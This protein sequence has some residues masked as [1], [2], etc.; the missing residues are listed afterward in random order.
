MIFYYDEQIRKYLLQF[1]R[2]FGSFTVQ[3]GFDAQS[4]PVY[5]QVPARYGDMSRQVGHILKDNSENTLNTIPFISCYVGSLEMKPDLRRYPQ[6]EE[7]LKVIEKKFDEDLHAYVE[8][9]GQ[10]YDVTRYTPVPYVLTMT[11]DIW[12]SNTDQKLQLLEQILVLF[13][14]GINLHTNENPLDWTS[15][16]YCEMIG[17]TWSSRTLPSGADNSIDVA[18]LTFQMPI[19][20]NPPARVSRMNIIQTILTQ[21]HTLDNADFET[22]S[23][24]DLVA[25]SEYIVTTLENYRVRYENGFATLLDKTG[26]VDPTLN[27]KTDVFSAYGELREGISQ[28]RLRQGNDVTDPSNDVIGTLNYDVSD[29]SRLIVNIDTDTLPIDTQGTVNNVINPQNNYPNDG[30]LPVVAAGQRYLVLDSTPD[31]SLW[32]NVTA[33]ANDIIKYNGSA[34]VVEFDASVNA[35]ANYVTNLHNGVQFEWT[36][37]FWQNSYEG[38]Y[39]EGWFRLYV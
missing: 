38:T 25:D 11:V 35:G 20:I 18:T 32:G 16:T 3:K 26:A 22:W 4:N 17:T 19:F 5:S 33:S 15:L 7:T 36:G 29:V 21:V 28:I 31:D 6:F 39:K 30:T 12:T 14:P 23:V 9:P 27:W 1:I 2:V 8:E 34:W 24:G 10:S 13:N 37:E